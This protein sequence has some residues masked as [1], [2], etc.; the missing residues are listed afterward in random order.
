MFGASKAAS[1]IIAQE[2]GRYFGLKVGVFRGGCLTGT[3]HSA[4]ELHGFLNYLVRVAL[5]D[6][7]YTIFGYKGKQVRDQIHSSDVVELF[8]EFYKSPRCG[9]VYNLGGGR[10]NSASILECMKLIE[11]A[12]GRKIKYSYLEQNRIGDHICYISNL[13]K[14]KKHFPNWK[15]KQPLPGIILGMIKNLSEVNYSIGL[16][17][18]NK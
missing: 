3:R 10:E 9:E 15:I 6:K 1:D 18:F 16:T 17:P 12:I 13:N 8:Y 11:E 5:T 14:I 7:E 2:Y 4:V